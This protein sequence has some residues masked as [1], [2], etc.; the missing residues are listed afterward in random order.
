MKDR[1]VLLLQELLNE[2]IQQLMSR[3]QAPPN[4]IKRAVDRLIEREYLERD[5]NNRSRL[6]YVVSH[7]SLRSEPRS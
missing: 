4:L 5:P 3:F 7:L 1:K 6:T 2:V